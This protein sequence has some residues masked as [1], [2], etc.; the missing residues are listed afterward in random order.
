MMAEKH[1]VAKNV[2]ITAPMMLPAPKPPAPSIPSPTGSNYSKTALRQSLIYSTRSVCISSE[3]VT[4]PPHQTA[5]FC[6]KEKEVEQKFK[7]EGGGERKQGERRRERG[8]NSILHLFFIHSFA[9]RS[10]RQQNLRMRHNAMWRIR[11]M[12]VF[13]CL[14]QLAIYLR[15]D[16]LTSVRYGSRWQWLWLKRRFVWQQTVLLSVGSSVIRIMIYITYV[17]DVRIQRSNSYMHSV[18][19]H[20]TKAAVSTLLKLLHNLKY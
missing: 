8:D 4:V 14:K 17:S 16:L 2:P 9:C 11:C 20:W 5:N 10:D 18:P 3:C 6:P 12:T 15:G 13:W 7:R 19:L 1:S